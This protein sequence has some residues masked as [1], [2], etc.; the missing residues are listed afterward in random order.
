MSNISSIIQ[1]VKDLES[2]EGCV[3]KLRNKCKISRNKFNKKGKEI[4]LA[5]N[6]TGLS[7]AVITELFDVSATTI[8]DII[9]NDNSK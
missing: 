4:I 1:Q 8:H 9:V 3:F 2:L 7:I 5:I 6:K